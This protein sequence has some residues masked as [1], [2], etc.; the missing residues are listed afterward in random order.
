MKYLKIN[1]ELL[2]IVPDDSEIIPE[3]IERIVTSVRIGGQTYYPTIFFIDEYGRHKF[4]TVVLDEASCR[5]DTIIK[6]LSKEEFDLAVS[7]SDKY[8]E[9]RG[10]ELEREF[11]E[12][13]ENL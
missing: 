7:Q 10:A 3:T 4:E 12:S 2:C 6:E 13:L 1:T 5:E 11:A 8:F 9:E